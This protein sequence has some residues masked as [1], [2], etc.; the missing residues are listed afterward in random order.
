M[1]VLRGHRH[2]EPRANR[3]DENNRF[4]INR[5]KSIADIKAL[6]DRAMPS[7][8]PGMDCRINVQS[9]NIVATIADGEPMTMRVERTEARRGVA[10]TK[11]SSAATGTGGQFAAAVSRAGDAQ[12]S[13]AAAQLSNVAA[14]SGVDAVVALQAVDG[15]RAGR[16]R[17]IVRGRSILDGLDAL[18]VALL[19]GSLTAR[20]IARLVDTVAAQ[21]T[22]TDDPRLNAVLDEIDLRAQVELAK[23]DRAAGR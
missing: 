14:L 20:Q 15:D 12:P 11:R 10:A 21:R 13:D 6:A 5:L 4:K 2:S 22:L 18:R 19:D 17:A 23:Y 16:R 7:G 9:T 8:S 1:R 3:M